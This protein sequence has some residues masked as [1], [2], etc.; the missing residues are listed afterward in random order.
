MVGEHGTYQMIAI[1]IRA[2]GVH[3][4]PSAGPRVLDACSSATDRLAS[5]MT[6]E[7]GWSSER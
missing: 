3:S 7:P 6:Y 1:S 2:S 4:V 5:L